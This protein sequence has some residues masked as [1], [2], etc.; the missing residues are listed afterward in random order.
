MQSTIDW[1][2]WIACALGVG[3]I[4]YAIVIER[5]ARH[6]LDIA[7]AGLVSL[8]PA[9]QGENKEEIVTAINDLLG[10]LSR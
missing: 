10:K 4:I 5:R 9:I 3:A 2:A 8:K 7:H 1:P 6:R